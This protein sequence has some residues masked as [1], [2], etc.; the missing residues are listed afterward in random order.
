MRDIKS[1]LAD[2]GVK[3][4]VTIADIGDVYIAHPELVDAVICFS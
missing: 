3:T 4:L 1:A 2:A